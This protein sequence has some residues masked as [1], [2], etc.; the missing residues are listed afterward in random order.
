MFEE[1]K[2]DLIGKLPGVLTAGGRRENLWTILAIVV[3]RTST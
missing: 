1:K 2:E 3:N